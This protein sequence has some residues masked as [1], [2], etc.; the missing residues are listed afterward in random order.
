MREV[1]VGV[2]GLGRFGRLHARVLLELPNCRVSALCEVHEP[3]LE[4]CGKEYG[5]T[6]LYTDLETMLTSEDLDAVDVVTDEP[7]HG[8]QARLCLEHGKAVFVE[9]PLATDGDDAE[10]VVKLSRDAG[11]PAVVGNISRFDAR[12]AALRRE[13]EAGRFGR[14]ALVQA[15]RS[16]SRAWFAGFG[17]RVHPVFE[18]MIH[19]LD[20]ALWYLGS[21]VRKVY[22]QANATGD[23]ARVP[24]TLVATLT[25][26]DGAL[27]VLQST[28]LV[29]DAAPVTLA[30]QPAGPLDLWGTIDAQLEVVGTSQM[31]KV[32]LMSGGLTLWND[33]AARLPDSGLWPEVHGRVTGAL[34]EELAHFLECVRTRRQ[35]SLVSA[36]TG[37][38]AVRLAEAIVRSSREGEAVPFPERASL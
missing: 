25:A 22:A 35:S 4:R 37:A 20:L 38:L 11:L 16:F 34:R 30:G 23:G 15:K 5:I 21:P 10:A 18:S 26:E 24:N 9:K 6:A 2:V 12:Y 13:L 14:V 3:D 36:E 8:E 31:G 32:D 29:P 7:A 19:D 17:S 33:S 28:W 27:A 1:K